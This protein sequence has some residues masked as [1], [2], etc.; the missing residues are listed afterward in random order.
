MAGKK[1]KVQVES[2]VEVT[3]KKATKPRSSFAV[4]EFHQSIHCIL[5][6]I[7]RSVR[8]STVSRYISQK[9]CE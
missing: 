6:T 3:S 4:D 8:D 2:E 5:M 7:K 9:C 1:K